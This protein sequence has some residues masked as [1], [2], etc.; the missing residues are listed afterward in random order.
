MTGM[1]EENRMF[2]VTVDLNRGYFESA[3]RG[4]WVLDT[5]DEFRRAVTDAGL[6]IQ[7]AGR[8]PISLC[9]YTGAMTQSQEVINALKTMMENPLVRCRR[10]AMYTSSV[11]PKMQAARATRTRPEVQFFT[12]QDEARAWLF[13]D[14]DA[15]IGASD[16]SPSDYG[17]PAPYAV[18]AR[19]EA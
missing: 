1:I 16:R 7:A 6:R 17:R 13:A 9:D 18:A 14:E 5:V 15:P 19:I 2:D 12:D 3:I 10:V 8:V 4:F 11:M